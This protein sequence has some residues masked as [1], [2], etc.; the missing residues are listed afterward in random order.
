MIP[1]RNIYYML[2]YAFQ[3]LKSDSYSNMDSEEFHNVADLCA[4]ILC[5]GVSP[6]I[7]R[8]LGRDYI[9]KT[10]PLSALR[11]RIDIADSI[12]TQSLL[13]QRLVCAYDDFSVN[14]RMNQIIKSTMILLLH[15]DIA[16]ERK[17]E[18]RRLLVYFDSVDAPEIHSIDWHIQYNRQ[19]ETYRML[20]AICNLVVKSLLQTTED[21]TEKIMDFFDEHHLYFGM[22]DEPIVFE[23]YAIFKWK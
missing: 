17:K 5:K 13:R 3:A 11:G 4:A 14:T 15:G 1:I 7:K 23:K 19:N 21:G 16:R 2:S 20:I 12:T 18:I 9:Q 22:M 8:G 6:Q 10:E